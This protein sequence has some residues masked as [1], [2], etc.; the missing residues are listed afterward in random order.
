MIS[1]LAELVGTTPPVHSN[2][3]IALE[4]AA[5]QAIDHIHHLKESFLASVSRLEDS[6]A[7]QC[8]E[9]MD[10][11]ADKDRTISGLEFQVKGLSAR[12]KVLT[13]FP[14]PPLL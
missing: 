8:N 3:S 1:E 10:V 4:T 2:S 7:L 12:F 9:I 5:A 14:Y 11:L 6:W 13:Y